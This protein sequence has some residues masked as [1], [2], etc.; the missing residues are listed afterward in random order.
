MDLLKVLTPSVTLDSATIWSCLP[1]GE[2]LKRLLLNFRNETVIVS[3]L[4]LIKLS[5]GVSQGNVTDVRSFCTTTTDFNYFTNIHSK[6]SSGTI[7]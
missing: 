7:A 3:L 4:S 1:A 5:K 6:S 2:D